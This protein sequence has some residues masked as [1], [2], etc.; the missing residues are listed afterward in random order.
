MRTLTLLTIALSILGCVTDG[1]GIPLDPPVLQHPD[2]SP[3]LRGESPATAYKANGEIC[4]ND[5]DCSTGACVVQAETGEH[6]CFGSKGVNEPCLTDFDCSTGACVGTSWP[7]SESGR[8]VCVH[9]DARCRAQGLSDDCVA[10]AI[11]TCA[12]GRACAGLTGSFDACVESTCEDLWRR[13]GTMDASYCAD[14]L[15]FGT[16]CGN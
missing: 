9:A 11:Q 6:R 1:R 10:L 4:V 15:S 8:K 16:G 5:S 13:K 3:L 7:A 12:Y 14:H 2:D